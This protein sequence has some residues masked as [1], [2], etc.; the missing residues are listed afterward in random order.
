MCLSLIKRAQK[1]RN[2]KIVCSNGA[3][4]KDDWLS[5]W[6]YPKKEKEIREI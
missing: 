4:S 5:L 3:G 6:I 1:E 2:N